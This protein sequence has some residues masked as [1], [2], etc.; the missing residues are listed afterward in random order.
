MGSFTAFTVA[1]LLVVS[2]L[3]VAAPNLSRGVSA[4]GTTLYPDHEDA[5]IAWAAPPGFELAPLPLLGQAGEVAEGAVLLL[6]RYTG[7]GVTEDSDRRFIRSLLRFRLHVPAMEIEHDMAARRAYAEAYGPLPEVRAIPVTGLDAIVVAEGVSGLPDAEG[8]TDGGRRTFTDGILDAAPAA[9]NADEIEYVLALDA[10]TAELFAHA[11]KTDGL[12]LSFAY[13]HW[14]EGLSSDT[15]INKGLPEELAALVEAGA[16]TATD[17]PVR[18][19]V[20]A[21]AMAI[22]IVAVRKIDLDLGMPPGYPALLVYDFT[23]D[24]G[25]A[26][27]LF[28]RQV[29]IEA[30]AVAGGRT[31]QTLLFRGNTPDVTRAVVRFPFAVDLARPYRF[32]LTRISLDGRPETTGWEDRAFWGAPLDLTAPPDTPVDPPGKPRDGSDDNPANEDMP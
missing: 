21:D 7:S 1:A 26:P 3:V 18:V 23:F 11:A 19:V 16:E 12:V 20:R 5:T 8:A 31:T 27:D 22:P 10:R 2:G 32:R 24:E 15:D 4:G 25:R 14:A 30:E 17:E 13:V 6:T 29:E 9:T 28:A